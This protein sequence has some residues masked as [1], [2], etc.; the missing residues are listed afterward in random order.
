MRET[1]LKTT[2][3]TTP[4]KMEASATTMTIKLET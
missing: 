3:R 4:L 2:V 1:S